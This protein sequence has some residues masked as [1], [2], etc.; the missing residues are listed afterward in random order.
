MPPDPNINTVVLTPVVDGD[1]LPDEPEKLMHN[2]ADTDYLAGVNN[3]DG[4]G[5][6]S[7]DIPS[8]VS[9]TEETPM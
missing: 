5:F 9:K 6:T 2:A 3:M 7:R 1:F 8:L 4:F